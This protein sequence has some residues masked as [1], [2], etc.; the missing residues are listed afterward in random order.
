MVAP[1]A[2][3]AAS[4]AADTTLAPIL[5]PGTLPA[6][7]Q[8]TTQHQRCQEIFTG[9]ME[10]LLGS[11]TPEQAK[12]V[13]ESSSKLG[14]VWLTTIP[15]QP[16]LRLTDFEVAVVSHLRT[17]AGEQG[18]HCT[19]CGEANFI[20]HPEVCLERKPWRVA[21]HE[22]DKRIIGQALASTPG[23]R[24]RL[25]PLG[26]QTSRRNDI[27]TITLLGSLATGLA[28]AEYDLTVVSLSSKEAHATYL[29]NQDTDPSRL[30]NKYLDSV[31]VS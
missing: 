28:N 23:T 15:F 26:H 3:A 10:A 2:Y 9:N 18:A 20:A 11:L 14:R 25:E 13:V 6:S 30:V 4:E 24:V 19:N 22:G 8:L 29:P 17:L 27:Q 31:A 16:F 7:T 21:R 5:T 1:H 12:A